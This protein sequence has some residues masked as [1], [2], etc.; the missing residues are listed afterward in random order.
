MERDGAVLT[1]IGNASGIG[2]R[3]HGMVLV[4]KARS[5]RARRVYSPKNFFRLDL[6]AFRCASRSLGGQSTWRTSSYM[7]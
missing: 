7:W 2:S 3:W 4:A 6:D 1:S 5:R